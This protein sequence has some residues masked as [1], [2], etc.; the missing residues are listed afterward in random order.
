MK[1]DQTLIIE[2]NPN[3]HYQRFHY[4]KYWIM[5]TPLNIGFH[6][7]TDNLYIKTWGNS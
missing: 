7:N 2:I 4:L 3:M 5:W 1:Q 6:H